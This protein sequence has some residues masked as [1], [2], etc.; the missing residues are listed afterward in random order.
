MPGRRDNYGSA[1][2]R[3]SERRD[4]HVRRPLRRRRPPLSPCPRLVA[5]ASACGGSMG[6]EGGRR[7]VGRPPPPPP[8]AGAPP[9][10]TSG[11]A[12]SVGRPGGHIGGGRPA[13]PAC[14]APPPPPSA[15]EG[16]SCFARARAAAAVTV[17]AATAA[18]APGGWPCRRRRAAP[19]PARRFLFLPPVSPASSR[20][21][22][23]AAPALVRRRARPPLAPPGS[24]LPRR[25]QGGYRRPRCVG[26][27]APLRVPLTPPFHDGGCAPHAPSP[28]PTWVACRR[29][30]PPHCRDP[31]LHERPAIGA[32]RPQALRRR[33]RRRAP[34]PPPRTFPRTAR[35]H[36]RR[37]GEGAHDGSGRAA[38]PALPSPVG[39]LRHQPPTLSTS[40]LS[41]APRWRPTRAKRRDRCRVTACSG[42][43][44]NGASP[45]PLKRDEPTAAPPRESSAAASVTPDASL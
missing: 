24:P 1:A 28:P 43:A 33:G 41:C 42:A 34:P 5:A 14:H 25:F 9:S 35:P 3:A 7:R 10:A 27:E 11:R 39:T 45:A 23:T 8:S 37:G 13:A 20:S 30:Q 4:G 22:A 12:Q 32:S 36:W 19:L 40:P 21:A 2:A 26:K 6:N 17:A 44:T 16:T 29:Q 38:P 31:A 15:W 18:G